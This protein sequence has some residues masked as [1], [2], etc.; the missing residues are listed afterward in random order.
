M[1]MFLKFKF[2][3]D[4]ELLLKK[5]WLIISLESILEVIVARKI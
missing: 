3:E 5:I 4:I 2:R 1:E